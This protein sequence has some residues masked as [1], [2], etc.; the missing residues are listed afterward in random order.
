MFPCLQYADGVGLTTICN[1]VYQYFNDNYGKPARH[2][3]DFQ[4]DK[5]NV[6]FRA[7]PQNHLNIKVLVNK[8]KIYCAL[9]D[10]DSNV[11]ARP[12]QG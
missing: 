1:D 10:Q 9:L 11:F 6:F 8:I 7:N 5:S 4:I 12:M 2:G 3:V